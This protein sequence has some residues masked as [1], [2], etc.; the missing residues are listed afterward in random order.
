M[1]VG[2]TAIIGLLGVLIILLIVLLVRTRRVSGGETTPLIVVEDR[3]PDYVY[4]NRP[5]VDYV[6][7]WWGWNGRWGWGGG[8]GGWRGRH[9]GGGHHGGGGRGRHH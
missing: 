6:Y 3:E 5:V 2:A 8:G 9:G 4:Y 1:K 7:P